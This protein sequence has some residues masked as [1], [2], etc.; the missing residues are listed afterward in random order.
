VLFGAFVFTLYSLAAATAN[1]MVSAEQR[2]QVA[3]A[4][5]ITYG[6][7]AVSGPIIAG[8]FMT[9][10][11]PQGLFYYFAL[12]SL[13]LASFAIVTR[14]RRAGSP[15]KRKPFVAVPS[16]Q[17]TSNQLYLSAHEEAPEHVTLIDIDEDADGK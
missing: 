1:D 12:V 10:L 15:D 13:M 11:G 8:Q 2:V 7:G 16:T 14:K 9:R 6:A 5:L 17:A 4:L 3:G